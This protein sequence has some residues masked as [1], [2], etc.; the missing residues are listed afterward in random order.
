MYKDVKVLSLSLSLSKGLWF[1]NS[2]ENLRFSPSQCFWMAGGVRWKKFGIYRKKNIDSW[3]PLISHTHTQPW[4][5]RGSRGLEA[6]WSQPQL[7]P[8]SLAE[9]RDRGWTAEPRETHSTNQLQRLPPEA[10]QEEA[11]LI[12]FSYLE[13]QF[14]LKKAFGYLDWCPGGGSTKSL[15]PSPTE[16]TYEVRCN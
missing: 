2:D 8:S 6:V 3:T 12:T 4:W 1:W 9:A 13:I 11:I 15:F 14:F 7:A 16:S 5:V 10:E